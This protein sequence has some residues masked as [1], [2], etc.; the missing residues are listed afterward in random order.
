[1]NSTTYLEKVSK[2][3]NDL[4]KQG[5][6]LVDIFNVLESAR[7]QGRQVFICGNGGSAGTANHMKADLFKIAEIKAISLNEN[8]SLATAIINDNG[9][10]YLYTDQLER[11]F[12]KGDILITISVH[13]GSGSDKAGLWSQNLMRA[14]HYVKKN[15]G[16]TIGFSGFDGG[17]MKKECDYC[18]VVP[19]ESTPLVEAFHVVLHHMIAFHLKRGNRK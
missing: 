7:E 18:I 5:H 4:K 10:E 19:A 2:V 17:A 12:N 8:M 3:S 9:W 1:M 6:I 16:T 11:L 13:G 15:K 14:I